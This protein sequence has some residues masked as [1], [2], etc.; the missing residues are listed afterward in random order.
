MKIEIP[1]AISTLVPFRGDVRRGNDRGQRRER[2]PQLPDTISRAA[3]RT[4]RSI[5]WARNSRNCA[6]RACKT[7]S[8]V[9][10]SRRAPTKSCRSP[11]ASSSNSRARARTRSLRS[12]R[13]FG[14]SMTHPDI[15]ESAIPGPLRN[16]IPQPD[17]TVDNTT[18][19][20][21]DFSQAYYQNLLFSGAPGAVSM[22]NFYI[23][24]SSNRYT[25]NG[26][27]T[28]WVQVPFNEAHYGANYC[29]GIVCARTWLFVRD[30]GQRLV[31]RADRRWARR[32]Q[33][34]TPTCR[35][36]TSGIATTAN[37]DGNFNQPDHYIDHFQIV[38]AG[39]GEE[40][41]GG[42]QGTD[43]IWSHRWYAFYSNIGLDGPP[44]AQARRH[45]D[46]R[47]ATTGSA[48]TPS[49]PRTAASACSRTSSATTSACPTCTTPAA[50]PAAPRTPPASGRC[51]QAARTAAPAVPADGIGSKPIPMS[52]YE[53][54]F[55]DWSNYQVV[56]YKQSGLGE[57]RTSVGEHQAGAAAQSC[58]S[59]TRQSS[60]SHRRP[61]RR[62]LLLLLGRR[63]QPRQHDDPSRLRCRPAPIA[64]ARRCST[65]SRADWDY[66]YL[67]DQRAR[68]VA[69]QTSASTTQSRMARTS[70]TGSPARC[71]RQSG[72]T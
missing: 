60:T 25:V 71:E 26:D 39:E 68:R 37:G 58:C 2:L 41:G 53:K 16:Q 7:T 20:A 12:W 47:S 6:S 19:W 57:A 18:I 56:G 51:I 54:I 49:S 64:S 14:T 3:S 59:P 30:A 10:R 67:T 72:S 46:R 40:T 62:A 23:E 69:D 43:A 48:T 8:R 52:A 21:P 1:I 24:Q 63:Q 27:V 70:A 31:Q 4:T 42:A 65:T 15:L 11:R 55:L 61:V 44:G 66:A 50:T 33:R 5:R 13:Q 34:S 28:D 22:R 38:H 45:P 17:R 29:G 35:S 36:S 32:V 9:R